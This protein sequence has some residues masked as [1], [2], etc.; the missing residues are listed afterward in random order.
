MGAA[1]IFSPEGDVLENLCTNL[2]LSHLQ[3]F[4]LVILDYSVQNNNFLK[5]IHLNYFC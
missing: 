2:Y 3:L 4:L 5:N 1:T